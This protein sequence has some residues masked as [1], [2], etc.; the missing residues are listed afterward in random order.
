MKV[1]KDPKKQ[2]SQTKSINKNRSDTVSSKD[3]G[4]DSNLAQKKKDLHIPALSLSTLPE[5]KKKSV[6]EKESKKQ[7]KNETEQEGSISSRDN[8]VHISKGYQEILK[9]VEKLD[10]NTFMPERLPADKISPE[11][12]PQEKLPQEKLQQE[13]LPPKLPTPQEVGNTTQIKV[14]SRFRP[15][16]SVETVNISLLI[17]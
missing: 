4:L 10:K 7:I 11:K 13:K 15:L 5:V 2:I 8:N 9:E 12:Q 1:L 14:I 3:K 6:A 16:N 17:K